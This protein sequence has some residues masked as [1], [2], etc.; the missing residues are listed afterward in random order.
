MYARAVPRTPRSN[1]KMRSAILKQVTPKEFQVFDLCTNKEWPPARV[2]RALHLF[3]PQVYYLN[4]KVTGLIERE[5]ARLANE[6]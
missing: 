3:R 5:A 1:M 6:T 2:A 4:K